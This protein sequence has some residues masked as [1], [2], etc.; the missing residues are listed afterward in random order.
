MSEA[1]PDLT[2]PEPNGRILSFSRFRHR[3]ANE[4]CLN[5]GRLWPSWLRKWD[6]VD[7]QEDSYCCIGCA[8]AAIEEEIQRLLQVAQQEKRKPH[9]IPLGLLLVSR[10]VITSGQ[11][12]EALRLQGERRTGRLGQWLQEL[13]AIKESEVATALGVQ[14]G[15]PVFPLEQ[16]HSYMHC[17]SLLPLWLLQAARVLPVYYSPE[18]RILY[19]AFT[20]RIDHTLLYAIE[21]MLGCRAAPCVAGDTAVAEA[22][23]QIRRSSQH[24]ESVFDSVRQPREMASVVG[25]YAV[26]LQAAQIQATYAAD[27][28]WFRFQNPQRTHDLLFQFQTPSNSTALIGAYTLRERL[29]NS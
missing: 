10:G 23:E 20:D 5:R 12:Q 1:S 26:K 24:R 13:G 15:C 25:H 7:F 8:E 29:S 9:R 27:H 14:W 17:A 18:S 2:R 21:Q 4:T 28:V 6:G 3:C 16:H 11:L 22:L 19:L